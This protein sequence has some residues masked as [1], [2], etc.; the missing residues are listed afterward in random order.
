MFRPILRTTVLFIALAWSSL[1]FCG[2]I[3]DAA[4]D[5]NLDKVKAL[6]QANPK[7]VTS[8]DAEGKTA[9]HWAATGGHKEVVQFLLD[10]K[11]DVHA[12]DNDGKT[13]LDL[14]SFHKDIADLLRQNGGAKTTKS[15]DPAILR[16]SCGR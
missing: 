2:E 13:P 4:K 14:A 12:K 11:A 15:H 10:S 3:Q 7:L 8:K 1:V 9:L 16:R 6:V 5:G